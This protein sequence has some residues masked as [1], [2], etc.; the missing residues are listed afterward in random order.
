LS[1]S[2]ESKI[3]VQT[4]AGLKKDNASYWDLRYLQNDSP[5]TLDVPSPPL[6]HFVRDLERSLSILVPGAG[7]SPDIKFLC[8]SGF[9]NITVCDISQ[10]AIERMSEN[11]GNAD[12]VTFI[13]DDFFNIQG[14]FDII[15]EQ[16]FFCALDPSERTGYVDKM[17]DLLSENGLF[18]GLLFNRYF[19]KPGPPYGGSKKEYTAL[20]SKRLHIIKM[21]MC[22]NSISPRENTELFFICKK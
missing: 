17:Y 7:C 16:T 4:A 19:D 9:S 5:W 1:I 14:T 3:V 2:Q 20:F 8:E 10:T 22:Y 12:M 18:A 6:V 15:L 11:L 21:E 13:C